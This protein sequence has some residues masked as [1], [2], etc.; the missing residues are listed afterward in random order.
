MRKTL[1]FY[2]AKE[3][4]LYFFISFLFF[5]FIFF[6]NQILLMAEEILSKKA[7]LGDVVLLIFY[8]LP[9]I[10]ATSAPFASLVG[11]LMGIGRLVSDKEIV[12]MNAL[13]V[14]IRFIM[15]PVFIVGVV[16]SIV[17]FMTNDILLPAGTIQ[18]N[19]LYK[20]I[21]T[22]TPALELE[23]N[24]IKRNQNAIVISGGIVGD[25][26]DSIM[27]IDSDSDGN[28]RV[29]A[30]PGARIMK[31]DSPDILMTL[32]MNDAV[33]TSLNRDDA[34]KFDVIT[35]SGIEYNVLT[36]NLMSA[37]SSSISP[38]EM[39]SRDLY[40][41]L[42]IKNAR[43]V[44]KNDKKTLNI[45]RMEYHKKF[46]VPFAAFFFTILAFPLGLTAK[47]NGQS[48]GFILGLIIAIL[49]W[50]MLFGGQTLSMRLG[51]NGAIMMWIPDATLFV[52]GLVFLGR[53]LLH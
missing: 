44:T 18:F 16:I 21:L 32:K 19:R 28:K 47:S 38:R 11:T 48:T 22:S 46:T 24:S 42:Q 9:S 15:V 5:F 4:V 7:E 10:I 25:L 36:K 43:S 52:L 33:V 3:M 41:E 27:L 31:S 20:K 26:M 12:I 6:V 49:Y 40:R 50:V 45:Y 53:R 14:P 29:V 23:S 35:S 17:S 13:G 51:V 8:S 1:F 30:A 2:I 34:N 39:S 37:Y